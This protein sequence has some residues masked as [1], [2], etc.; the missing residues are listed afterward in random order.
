ML[1]SLH[2]EN[3][4]V[5]K[6]IDIDLL[7]GFTVLTGETGAG[8]SIIIDSINL[9]LGSRPSREMIR[10]GEE[11]AVVS[12]FFTD[13]SQ[14][15]LLSLSE[16]GAEPD[17]EG[18]IFIQRTLSADGRTTN[19]INGR[20]VSVSLMR[21]TGNLL[22]NVH[23]QHEN[24]KLLDTTKHIEY[25]DKYAGNDPLAA[26]YAESYGKLNEIK[27]NLSELYRNEKE[28]AAM[29]EMLK[30][31]ISEIDS[32]HL[33]PNEDEEL[34][35]QKKRI[36]NIEKTE[37]QAKIIYDS[38]YGGDKSLSACQQIDRAVLALKQ[39]S[40]MYSG[41]EDSIEKLLNFRYEIED[42]AVRAND[43]KDDD[44]VNPSAA[45]DRLEA[46]LEVISRL[47]RKYGATIDEILNF[48]LKA[49]DRL[50]E[51]ETSEDKIRKLNIAYEIAEKEAVSCAELLTESRKT[52]AAELAGK[53][54]EELAFL[55]MEKVYFSIEVRR[56]Q[57]SR[58][59]G[60]DVEFMIST[61]PGEPVKPLGKIASG[62]ELSRVMLAIKSV[63]ADRENT[64]T[65]IFDEI[66]TGISGR[67]S[68][69]IGI[70]LKQTSAVS[71]VLCVTHS[72]QIAALAHNHLYV[73]KTE[74]GGR[75]ET[76]VSLLDFKG[77]VNE[78]ARIMGGAEI[79]G[80]LLDTAAEMLITAC[81]K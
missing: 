67:T 55:E 38:L 30:Y 14:A 58:S 15:N 74:C 24:Q 41:F 61:N 9:L 18:S 23:G 20:T 6:K 79:T 42:V 47:K 64:E 43:L 11:T 39:I 21:E 7:A 60:D 17:E 27:R 44:A 8:K 49:A 59:G 52:A 72:A 5:I 22:I 34:E 54:T 46:K 66:D 73:S 68:H 16:L 45:L 31:Q 78:I 80:K 63:L 33:K 65:L 37:K 29:T 13:I 53:I 25:L 32:A 4:A 62:G 3:V 26:A 50:E 76:E 40:D 48:R 81:G 1:V 75:V 28:K 12:A 10:S 56:S 71:Q 2:I 69:K 19:K 70:K 36:Q 35:I 57:L 51:F 77:R